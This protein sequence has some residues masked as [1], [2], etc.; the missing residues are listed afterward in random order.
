MKWRKIILIKSLK[1]TNKPT[2]LMIG[3]YPPPYGG[4]ANVI[5]NLSEQEVLCQSFTI[6]IYRTGKTTDSTS[7]P[8]QAVKDVIQI[9]KFLLSIKNKD[10]KIIHIHTASYWSFLRNVPYIMISR[11]LCKGKILVHIHGGEFYKFFEK[12]ST[13]IKKIIKKTLT[14]VSHIFVTSPSWIPII[15]KI[16]GN[17]FSISSIPNGFDEKN[18]FLSS[19]EKARDTLQLPK[20]NKIIITIGSLEYHKG[21][22]ILIESM[23]EIMQSTNDIITYIIGKGSLAEDLKQLINTDNLKDK[24]ILVGGDKRPE[25]VALWINAADIFVL[26]SLK[27]GNPT[28]MFECL[29]CGKPFVGSSV[30]GIPDVII[31]TEYGL[32]CEPGNAR[33]LKEKIQ[34][35]LTKEWNSEKIIKYAQNYTWA[36][37]ALEIS[38]V[39][40]KLIQDDDQAR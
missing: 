2:V 34:L 9:I 6:Q 29:A 31:S 26:P 5:K 37:I 20:K 8:I 17:D 12:A 36:N 14:S 32:L 35:A 10:A 25:E 38:D 22:H 19:Q 27:E 15:E 11:Y 21:H 1:N 4:I 13:P 24:I 28:V 39:Y 18:F 23:K 16:I 40:K 30:G 3:P 7:F 33:D